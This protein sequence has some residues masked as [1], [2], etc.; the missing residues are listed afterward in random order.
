MRAW[1]FAVVVIV[2][3]AA[4]AASGGYLIYRQN[5]GSAPSPPT[6]V[7]EGSNV[8]VNYIGIFGSGPEQGKVFDT[9]IYSVATNDALYPKSLEYQL[10]GAVANYTPLAVYVGNST[11][12]GGYSL[13]NLTFESVVDGFWQGIIGMV[14][15]TTRT[16]VVPEDLG[17]GPTDPAC[18]TTQPLVMTVPVLETL[19]G[20]DFS[21]AFPGVGAA[22]GKEFTD[23][24][25]GWTDQILS[26]NASFVTLERLPYVGQ[27][28]SPGG[29]PI[30]VTSIQAT[31]NG[32]GAITV[33]NEISAGDAGH[34]LGTDFL[35][36]APCN[37]SSGGKF[38][39]TEVNV[40][41]GTFTEDY[42]PEVQGQTLIFVV[43]VVDYFP[44]NTGS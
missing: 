33:A 29:W 24:H 41:N 18:L 42:N 30:E 22:V 23:P 38:I 4:V 8:T 14:P 28:T 44:P 17:Y 35:D 13:G 20:I 16:I 32:S 19:T 27:V 11:P 7:A 21:T 15:N 1:I 34:L 40:A 31:A 39:V 26:A 43:T 37:S 9:S 10:R 2:V 6:T 12:S 5:H 36:N 25:Y 3:V